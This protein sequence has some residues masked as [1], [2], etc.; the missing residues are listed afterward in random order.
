MYINQDEI[1]QT[2]TLQNAAVRQPVRTN[3]PLTHP[4]YAPHYVEYAVGLKFCQP[5][6]PPYRTR[7]A[8]DD[9]SQPKGG[10]SCNPLA[11][12][13]TYFPNEWQT[14]VF[15]VAPTPKDGVL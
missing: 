13:S 4:I 3:L 7:F 6:S 2:T 15:L 8:V 14:M 12:V 11:P 10:E 5:Q 9:R 1:T